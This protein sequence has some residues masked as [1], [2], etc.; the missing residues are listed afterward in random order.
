MANVVFVWIL[1]QAY[2][3]P[4]FS[5][6]TNIICCWD[7]G[8]NLR[9]ESFQR[10]WDIDGQKWEKKLNVIKLI[11]CCRRVYA[12]NE[13]IMVFNPFIFLSSMIQNWKNILSIQ[14][15]NKYTSLWILTYDIINGYAIMKE[16]LLSWRMKEN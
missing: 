4:M 7:R 12:W 5:R 9:L 3:I 1:M 11:T 16:I 15:F 13:Y 10:I 14:K 2:V 8:H 6:L